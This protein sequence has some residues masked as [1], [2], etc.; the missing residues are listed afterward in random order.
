MKSRGSGI[1]I[2][3][4]LIVWM[5]CSNPGCNTHSNRTDR[6]PCT[7]RAVFQDP[8]KSNY[9]LPFPVGNK[10]ILSQS[11]CYADGGHR[12]QL[13]YDFALP[14]GADVT[15]AR[16]GILLETRSDLEDTGNSPDPGD[17]NHIF[18]QHK[19]GSVAFYAHLQQNS[20]ELQAGDTVKTGQK[21]ASSGNSG[22]TGNF[23]HLHFG[24]YQ[25]WPAKE[26]E[27]LA[28]SFKNA[29]GPLDSLGGLIAD[30]WYTAL[31]Y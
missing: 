12:N 4:L 27:D 25:G 10:Y 2:S 30:Q 14:V 7:E 21:I 3:G 17:H 23:P 29:E 16:G 1:V 6:K 19:D 24:V 8:A 11:Y 28:V 26:G 20:I 9:I 18:I 31:P 5:I 15:A 13:A 22:N